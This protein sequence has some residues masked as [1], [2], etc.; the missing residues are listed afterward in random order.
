ML[1]SKCGKEKARDLSSRVSARA[2]EADILE[3][4]RYVFEIHNLTPVQ[5][6][7]AM[8]NEFLDYFGVRKIAKKIKCPSALDPEKDL[9][10]IAEKLYPGAVGMSKENAVLFSYQRVCDGTEKKFPKKFF[11]EA[12]GAE[13]ACIILRYVINQYLNVDSTEAL[14]LYFSD[15]SRA[16]KFLEAHRLAAVCKDMYDSPL[17]FLYD[18]MGDVDGNKELYYIY[19]KFCR[20]FGKA[21][22]CHS[23]KMKKTVSP[24]K[25]DKLPVVEITKEDLFSARGINDADTYV[26]GIL[27]GDMPS[28]I[29]DDAND[30][31]ADDGSACAAAVKFHEFLTAYRSA[32]RSH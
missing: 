32:V 2:T 6:Y 11:A 7:N 10:Y 18:A 27:R 31:A 23:V 17:D 5:V 16:R 4:L 26:G 22:S 29:R 19:A 15:S 20:E 3:F 1:A 13:N 21:S 9:F 12:D 28:Y 8:S 30:V 14:Y 24:E 25:Y